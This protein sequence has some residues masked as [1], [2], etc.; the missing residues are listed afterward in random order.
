MKRKAGLF[1]YLLG[2]IFLINLIQAHFTELI[3]DEAYYWYYAQNMAW[4]YFDHPPMVALL[5][6]ISSL[7]FGGEL[8]VRF[9]SSVLMAGTVFTLWHL[10]YPPKKEDYIPHFFVLVFSMTLL[11]AYGFL[12]LPDTPL[13]FFTALFLWV[14]KKFLTAPTAIL[15]IG[16]GMV[17]AALMYSKYHAVL[18][19]VFVLISNS[20]LVFNKYAWLAVIVSLLCYSP[21][22]LWLFENDFISIKYHLFERPNRAYHFEDYTL[23]YLI[24][25]VALFGLTFPWIYLSVFRTKASDMFTRGLLY[26]TYGVLLFFFISSFNRRIQTQ[27]LIVICIP[28]VVLV[29][30]Y[31]LDH[32]NTRKWIWRCGIANIVLFCFLRIGLV[33]EPFFPIVY[34]THGNKKWVN[35]IASQ[36]G[37]TPVVFEN[38]Y[39]NAPMYS[40]Y[41]GFTS[42]SLNNIR[43]RQNQYSIDSSEFRVQHK[44]VLYT[45]KYIKEGD[46]SFT[47]AKGD[48]YYGTYID[49]FESFRK[50]RCYVADKKNSSMEGTHRLNVY[51]PYKVDIDLA[52]IKFSVA[53]LNAHK[54]VKELVPVTVEALQPNTT[55]LTSRD[56]TGFT[57]KLPVHGTERPA[58]FKICI[59]EN[60]L[61]WGLNGE[62]VKLQ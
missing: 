10:V 51:N 52:K 16:L 47:T 40:F 59:S 50:L 20:K 9:M 32:S 12:T 14:Y 35:E 57:F 62:N 3:F 46:V 42:F 7:F 2:A 4:G 45:S 49:S 15:S 53:Y 41:S 44:R 1:L 28:V 23:G 54:Q 18:V 5:V 13:L 22:I 43:Y 55:V 36:V 27:W 33:Y 25:L 31:M 6:K 21:H 61:Y 17:M 37:S 11:N 24:N 39:R 34:E 38:S 29:F 58:Y 26:L 48:T 19:I 8:G 60:N 56:S 30:N